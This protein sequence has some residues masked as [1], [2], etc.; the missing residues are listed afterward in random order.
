MNT[1]I[2]DMI[3]EAEETLGPSS[4]NKGDKPEPVIMKQGK[5]YQEEGSGSVNNTEPEEEFDRSTL[6]KSKFEFSM[7]HIVILGFFVV[8]IVIA[9]VMASSMIKEFRKPKFITDVDDVSSEVDEFQEYEFE[10]SAEEKEA[11]RVNGFT[12]DEIESNEFDCV[13]SATLI[14][15]SQRLRKE[16][17]DKEYAPYLDSGSPEF[18]ALRANTWVGLPSISIIGDSSKYV[19]KTKTLNTDYVKLPSTGNQ[20]WLKV[21]LSDTDH[22]KYIFMMVSPEKYIQ[23]KEEGNIVVNITYITGEEKGIVTEVSEVEMK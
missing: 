20:L 14:A 5:T 3:K 9:V 18:Q 12:G 6:K 23:Y 22:S 10:Y 7:K 15:E 11:L 17:Y 2:K 13:P 19:K 16:R 4:I 21:Y 8:S 1:S